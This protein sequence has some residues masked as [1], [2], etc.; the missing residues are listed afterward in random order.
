LVVDDEHWARAFLCEALA[1]MGAE[2]VQAGNGAEALEKWEVGG[3]A[4]VLTDHHMP[5]ADGLTLVSSLRRRG[6]DGPVWVLSGG[7]SA[8]LA[9]AYGALGVEAVL[10]KPIG[11]E[12]LR[13]QV[14][15]GRE[16]L[17]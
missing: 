3:V 17:G 11:L 15:T 9:E 4:A 10:A 13:A 5:V 6:F 8:E 12:E 14:M 16:R 2:T 1:V 7:M